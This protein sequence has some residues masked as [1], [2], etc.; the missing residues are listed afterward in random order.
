VNIQ[1][2]HNN[3][4]DEYNVLVNGAGVSTLMCN[5]IDISKCN[6]LI[7]WHFKIA[8][9]CQDLIVNYFVTA[10]TILIGFRTDNSNSGDSYD[11]NSDSACKSSSKTNECV[12]R[13]V[14]SKLIVEQ[15][16]ACVN[17]FS[18]VRLKSSDLYKIEI[19]IKRKQCYFFS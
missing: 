4:F 11:I 7:S 3:K 16:K 17:E 8:Y 5:L 19:N 15:D 6:E 12:F 2:A 13:F 1:S 9:K 14:E 18:D 10:P